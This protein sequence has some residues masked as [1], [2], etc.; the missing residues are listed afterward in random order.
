MVWTIIL[1]LCG[2]GVLNSLYVLRWSAPLPAAP[3]APPS[4]EAREDSAACSLDDPGACQTLFTSPTARLTAGIPNSL[5]GLL[6]YV[7]V[8]GSAVA[9]LRG[10]TLPFWW[11]A[12]LLLAAGAAAGMSVWLAWHLLAVRRYFCVPC[13]IGHGINWVLLVLLAINRP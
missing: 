7:G 1:I 6:Y 13:F 3:V 8:G 4:P 10:W 2:L 11:D 12:G 5:L 9:V